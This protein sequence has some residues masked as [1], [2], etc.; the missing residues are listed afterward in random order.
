LLFAVVGI[1]AIIVSAKPSEA[2]PDGMKEIIDRCQSQMGQYGAAMVKA[3]VDQEIQ[4]V[5]AIV[6]YD[7]K[8]HD[9]I[10]RCAQQM[11]QYG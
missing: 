1:V 8:Y 11:A 9:I 4:A 7:P 3:C 5:E 6:K 2:A 10:A